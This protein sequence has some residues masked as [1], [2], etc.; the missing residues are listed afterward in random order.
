MRTL[1]K[2]EALEKANSATSIANDSA[3]QALS[4]LSHDD[5]ETLHAAYTARLGRPVT[6]R[7]AAVRQLMS[8]H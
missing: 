3:N 6:D 5:T 2:I 1:P 7:Q 4:S 8:E